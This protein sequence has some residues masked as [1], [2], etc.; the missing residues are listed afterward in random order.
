MKYISLTF[1]TIA[2]FL[3][4]SSALSATVG[5]ETGI[6][7]DT[8]NVT[9][10]VKHGTHKFSLRPKNSGSFDKETISYVFKKNTKT[11]S[12]MITNTQNNKAICQLDT[13]IETNYI[14]TSG[15]SASI[16]KYKVTNLPGP[17]YCSA[18][19]GNDTVQGSVG[20]L[21]ISIT[22]KNKNKI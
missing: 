15:A 11:Y 16:K 17:D 8:N 3:I 20:K 6:H 12:T 9:I 14:L 22:V 18:T 19:I 4:N 13:T 1:T 21:S 7:N 5:L 2:L 10:E